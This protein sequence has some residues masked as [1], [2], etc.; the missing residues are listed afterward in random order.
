MLNLIVSLFFPV[1][2]QSLL[3]FSPFCLFVPLPLSLSSFPLFN[4]ERFPTPLISC[5]PFSSP[6]IKRLSLSFFFL[7]GG[8]L[9]SFVLQPCSVALV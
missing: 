9:P 6:S 5:F 2:S 8:C 4:A 7:V 3:L 1:V